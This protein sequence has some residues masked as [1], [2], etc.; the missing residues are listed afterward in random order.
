MTI[1]YTT[2]NGSQKVWLT[3]KR[4]VCPSSSRFL[5]PSWWLKPDLLV[6]PITPA[7]Q[8]DRR[9][10]SSRLI[11]ASQQLVEVA[12]A[13]IQAATRRIASAQQVVEQSRDVRQVVWGSRALRHRRSGKSGS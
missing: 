10:H 3:G 4:K 7:D 8:D 2:I 5:R 9:R 12:R 6:A 11:T 13:Q 1:R